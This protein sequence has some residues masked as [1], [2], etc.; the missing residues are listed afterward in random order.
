MDLKIND[1]V[2]LNKA[3]IECLERNRNDKEVQDKNAIFTIVGHLGYDSGRPIYELENA[4]LND[5]YYGEHVT[6]LTRRE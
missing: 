4:S 6:K 1:N 2:K 5:L 3:G